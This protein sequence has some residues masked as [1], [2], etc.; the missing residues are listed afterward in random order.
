MCKKEINY[1][2]FS[3]SVFLNRGLMNINV[4]YFSVSSRVRRKLSI[5]VIFGETTGLFLSEKSNSIAL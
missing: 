2:R 5:L 3:L 1:F 4:H